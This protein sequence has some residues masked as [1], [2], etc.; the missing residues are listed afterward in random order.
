[1]GPFA[2]A[3]GHG[4]WAGCIKLLDLELKSVEGLPSSVAFLLNRGYCHQKLMLNRKAL[5]V[6]GDVGTHS[7]I[8]NQVIW[9]TECM[10]VLDFL[11]NA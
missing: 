5:K 9:V 4:D 10:T 7:Q 1:M 2:T 3:A 11:L 6:T 8:L